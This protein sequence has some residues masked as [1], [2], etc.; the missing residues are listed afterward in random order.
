MPR[1][2]THPQFP[3]G[4]PHRTHIQ[5][6]ALACIPLLPPSP[7][8]PGVPPPPTAAVLKDDP[9]V[10]VEVAPLQL[11]P[12]RVFPPLCIILPLPSSSS[13]TSLTPP[14]SPGPIHR[15]TSPPGTSNSDSMAAPTR[16]ALAEDAAACRAA[17]QLDLEYPTSEDEPDAPSPHP[18]AFHPPELPL[19]PIPPL[20]HHPGLPHPSD[21]S[22]PTLSYPFGHLTSGTLVIYIASHAHP[23]APWTT[24][25]ARLRI[26]SAHIHPASPQRSSPVVEIR[27]VL[28]AIEHDPA[29]SLTDRLLGDYRS[30]LSFASVIN[31]R[32]DQLEPSQSGYE[33]IG[34][35]AY[36]RTAHT[37]VPALTGEAIPPHLDPLTRLQSVCIALYLE[38]QNAQV[39]DDGPRPPPPQTCPR[40]V[41]PLSLP[42]HSALV[43]LLASTRPEVQTAL[44]AAVR[45]DEYSQPENTVAAYRTVSQGRVAYEVCHN[46]DSRVAVGPFGHPPALG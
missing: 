44:A 6:G 1:R 41:P 11:L 12:L 7:P 45:K 39:S 22:T 8:P 13:A 40:G 4:S 29:A 19:P 38:P 9:V 31:L 23:R 20:Y 36:A 26:P 37:H 14:L 27:H 18:P 5:S 35:V 21:T 42:E 34:T 33:T 16:R 3:L 17:F 30:L 24:Q 15:T 10:A 43:M 25:S 32:V 2:T 28:R 46:L